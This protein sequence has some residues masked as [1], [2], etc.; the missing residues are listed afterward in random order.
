MCAHHVLTGD[1]MAIIW[2]NA[3]EN[4]LMI[5]VFLMQ[6]PIEITTEDYIKLLESIGDH[7]ENRV[8]ARFVYIDRNRSCDGWHINIDPMHVFQTVGNLKTRFDEG[9]NSTKIYLSM[10]RQASLDDKNSLLFV[11][12]A[13]MLDDN[14]PNPT[15]EA[16]VILYEWYTR[17]CLAIKIDEIR[18]RKASCVIEAHEL[19][20]MDQEVSV[21][22]RAMQNVWDDA[23]RYGK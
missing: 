3:M 13:C 22:E 12:D 16:W 2:Y 4:Y 21:S 1:K 18:S 7:S 23:K 8:Y 6:E 19:W 14:K 20:L 15:M 10:S 5:G 17:Q 9:S 11:A